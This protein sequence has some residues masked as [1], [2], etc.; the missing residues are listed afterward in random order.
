MQLQHDAFS[1]AILPAHYTPHSP[2]YYSEIG[3]QNSTD[4]TKYG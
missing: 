4:H 2:R 3:N 1:Y